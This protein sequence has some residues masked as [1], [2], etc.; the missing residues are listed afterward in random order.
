M[1]VSVVLVGNASPVFL[2]AAVRLGKLACL[3]KAA[4]GVA[5]MK[6]RFVRRPGD[7][8]PNFQGLLSGEK[9]HKLGSEFI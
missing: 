4:I 9:R 3:S 6:F 2:R 8:A 5:A 1:Q 7:G